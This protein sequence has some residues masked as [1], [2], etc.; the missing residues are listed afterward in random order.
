MPLTDSLAY[1]L[2]V[3]TNCKLQQKSFCSFEPNNES[4]NVFAVI[5]RCTDFIENRKE[6]TKKIFFKSHHFSDSNLRTLNKAD[7]RYY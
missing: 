3:T 1:K 6:T 7:L 5:G 4:D 2:Q